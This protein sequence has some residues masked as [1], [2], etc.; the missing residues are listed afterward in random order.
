ML[1]SSFYLVQQVIYSPLGEAIILPPNSYVLTCPSA[2][3]AAPI[4]EFVW[5]LRITWSLLFTIFVSRFIFQVFGHLKI[6]QN[7]FFSFVFRISRPLNRLFMG[8]LPCIY[9]IDLGIFVTYY[10]FDQVDTILN[11][12]VIIDQ[13]GIVY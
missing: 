5:C 10:L 13:L 8:V 4:A 1:E 11:H 6:Y 3:F 9:G 7:S 2:A 12:I